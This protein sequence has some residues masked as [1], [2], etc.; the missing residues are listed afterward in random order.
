MHAIGID[1]G[2]TSIC[3]VLLDART[4]KLIKRQTIMS[5]AFI[6]TENSWEKIQDTEKLISISK[7]IL[8]GL[9]DEETVV[10]GL[11]G[12]MH[13][14]VYTDE[15]GK[16]L[17]PLYTCQDEIGNLP[18]R[19]TTYAKYM[20]SLAG[21]GNVTDF[22]NRENG[23]R[24]KEAVSYCTIQDYLGMVLCGRKRPVLH[25]SNAASF[26]CFDAEK[27]TDEYRLLGEYKKVPVAVAIGDNQAS[28]FSTLT[29]ESGILI[30]I[31]TGS[32]I[33]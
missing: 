25:S 31:G 8:D 18:D 10:I 7:E 27:I 14:I 17:S 26:D 4:G 6:P 33:T 1:I 2:T 21:Y 15:S 5:N 23:L 28:V 24:P 20:E 9:L 32:Q 16:A 12:Q 13:G 30:N 11:T 22:Y 29:D 3:G 19:D